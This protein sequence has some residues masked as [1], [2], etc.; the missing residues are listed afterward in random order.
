[1][2]D[3]GSPAGIPTEK[4]GMTSCPNLNSDSILSTHDSGLT[5][6]TSTTLRN[7]AR[8]PREKHAWL[9]LQVANLKTH[10]SLNSLPYAHQKN[11]QNEA[12]AK[13]PD[14]N[15]GQV[16]PELVGSDDHQGY[17]SADGC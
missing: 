4:S 1:M 3:P 8:N 13:S 11:N 6:Q 9:L 15:G 10:F 16:V 14:H 7:S 2:G 12:H 17:Q 5:T